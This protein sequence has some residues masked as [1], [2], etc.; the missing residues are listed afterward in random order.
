MSV[1]AKVTAPSARAELPRRQ[2]HEVLTIGLGYYRLN[3]TLID[4][5]FD[6]NGTLLKS[7]NQTFADYVPDAPHAAMKIRLFDLEPPKFVKDNSFI[8]TVVISNI[9]TFARHYA[10][11]EASFIK[12]GL[13]KI[14]SAAVCATLGNEQKLTANLTVHANDSQEMIVQLEELQS[15]RSKKSVSAIIKLLREL[16]YLPYKIPWSD[17]V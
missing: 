3:K 4:K 5:L 9:C 15:E 16:Q 6:N 14:G 7:L 11:N 1:R 8:V 2:L 17:L 13:K 12:R 10:K